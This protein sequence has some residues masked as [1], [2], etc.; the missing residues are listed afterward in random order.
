MTK[1]ATQQRRDA[2]KILSGYVAAFA[3]HTVTGPQHRG[4]AHQLHHYITARAAYGSQLRCVPAP[5]N[6]DFTHFAR[7]CITALLHH[8]I[9]GPQVAPLLYHTMP[10]SLF[11]VLLV[12]R[13]CVTA[14]ALL[15][16]CVVH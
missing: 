14:S 2:V 4:L 13:Y 9:A 11:T 16:Y 3:C 15:R 6:H 8:C 10:K 5:Q 12:Q 1:T 7:Y